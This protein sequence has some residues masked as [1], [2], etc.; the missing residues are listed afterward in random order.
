M[1][2]ALG[3]RE[4]PY[5]TKPLKVLE[6]DVDLLMGRESEQINFFTAMESQNEGVYIL[7]GVPGV[8]KTSFF[9]IQ[10]Y[11][12][13]SGKAY[14]GPQLLAAR[15]LC[16]IQPSDEPKFI[17]KRCLQY[18]CQ[19]I[20]AYCK[21]MQIKVPDMCSTVLTWILQNKPASFNFGF[22]IMGNG[23]SFGRQV[24]LPSFSDITYETIIE[25][26]KN[27][28]AEVK[29]QLG[30]KG[31]FIA[32]D[33]IENLEEEDLHD[34]LT[35]FRDTLFMIPNVWWILIGQSGLASLIQSTNP[36]VYQRISGSLELKP[37]SV[38]N[39]IDAVDIRVA[40]FHEVGSKGASPI[41][42]DIYVKLFKSS[43]GEIRFVFNYCQAICINLVQTIR[44]QLI[45]SG[46]RIEEVSINKAIGKFLVKTQINNEYSN[47]SLK[48]LITENF[49][50]LHLDQE[51]KQVLKKIG[52][53]SKVKPSDFHEFKEI[54]I[55]TMQGLVN[56]YLTRL[57]DQQLLFRRQ[58]GK[59]VTYELRGISL[60]AMEYDLLD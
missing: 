48:Q 14:F 16:P 19:S 33:N 18:F 12:L 4:S 50:G 13:E 20:E 31:C 22:S 11:L 32:L 40:R 54:G 39:L 56:N 60:F 47:N 17:A 3:F 52:Q 36:K 44:R 57:N 37:I 15:A 55:T 49:N 24:Q 28:V 42:K 43:N 7:S 58:E 41:T 25:I 35:T 30:L 1:W 8:G 10:Q 34:C 38:E 2:Q 9:N 23:L 29:V 5:D 27:L 6:S 51:E 21:E 53:L 45:E 59:I 26:I 46:I